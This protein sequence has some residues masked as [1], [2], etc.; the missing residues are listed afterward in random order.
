MGTLSRI[1]MGSAPSMLSGTVDLFSG[2]NTRG[3]PPLFLLL[4]SFIGTAFI[5]DN[6]LILMSD[7]KNE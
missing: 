5:L 4:N 7:W 1:A 6:T 3:N 2:G